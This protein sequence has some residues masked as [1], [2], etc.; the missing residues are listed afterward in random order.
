M[1]QFSSE[2]GINL[3][4]MYESIDETTTDVGELK[5]KM[6][7]LK[8]LLNLNREIM[9]KLLKKSPPREPVIKTWFETG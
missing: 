4:V 6:G 3:D 9:E 5:D 8:A 7:R 1:K 2:N